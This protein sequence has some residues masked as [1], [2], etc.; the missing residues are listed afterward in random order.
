LEL[1]HYE[2]ADH[3]TPITRGEALLE[4]LRGSDQTAAVEMMRLAA[5]NPED[6]ALF[7]DV[8]PMMS[9]QDVRIAV[10]ADPAAAEETITI[11]RGHRDGDW[12]RRNFDYANTVIRWM[13]RVA[14]EAI[15]IGDHDLLEAAVECLFS[16]DADWDRWHV[17]R[18]IRSWLRSLSGEAAR[19]AGR[20]LRAEKD[21]AAHFAS[22][23]EETNIDNAVRAAVAG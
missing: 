5:S 16:W 22:L 3:Q 8:L 2:L 18:E 23:A 7:V 4:R 15:A 11:L 20:G 14:Q 19:V 9:E 1:L 17:Q 12:G 6:H 10:R 21:A 13:L